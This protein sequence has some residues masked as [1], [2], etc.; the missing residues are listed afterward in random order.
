MMNSID[1]LLVKIINIGKTEDKNTIFLIGNTAKIE[2]NNFYFTPVRN[3][4]QM[5]VAGIVVYKESIAKKIAKKIDGLVD[6]IFVD[7]EKKISD[8]HSL[9]G[10]PGNIERAVKE[11]VQKSILITY[12]ANDLTI[13]AVDAFLSEYYLKEIVGIGG[14]KV[15]IIGAGNI[16]SKLALKLVER[17]ANVFLYRRNK[18]KLDLIV[19]YINSIKSQYTVAEDYASI[20]CIEACKDADILIGATNGTPVINKN[21][22]SSNLRIRDNFLVIDIGKGSVSKSAIQIAH[23]K[24]IEVYRLGV[25]SALE[26]MIVSLI[27]T[28]NIFS[29]RTGRGVFHKVRVVSGG[30]LAYDNEIIVDN[31]NDPKIIYGVGN[32]VGDF[33]RH[34][35][36]QAVNKIKSLEEI[37]NKTNDKHTF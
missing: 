25:E 37:I 31:Y 12:K 17:G 28:H 29:K 3:Y 15:A 32:G 21:I 27:S 9:S 7:A 2:C 24:N 16:G 34:P 13:E 18:V 10:E 6:Y 35:N 19:T 20:S 1:N 26:G 14:K 36:S 8:S 5:I 22:I 23:S 4:D 33:E 30:L 11:V